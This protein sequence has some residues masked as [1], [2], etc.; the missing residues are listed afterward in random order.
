MYRSEIKSF[1]TQQKDLL[2]PVLQRPGRSPVLAPKGNGQAH[3]INIQ[4]VGKPIGGS[5]AIFINW[6]TN[7][8]HVGPDRRNDGCAIGC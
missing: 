7:L 5:P 3:F 6:D 1:L 4:P 2:M 8:L